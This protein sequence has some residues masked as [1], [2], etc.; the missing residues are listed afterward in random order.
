MPKNMGMPVKEEIMPFYAIVEICPVFS[1][2]FS[3]GRF[4][5]VPKDFRG[6]KIDVR[7]GLVEVI[8]LDKN[9]F[10]FR[11]GREVRANVG[12]KVTNEKGRDVNRLVKITIGLYVDLVLDCGLYV[13][14]HRHEVTGR[15]VDDGFNGAVSVGLKHYGVSISGVQGRID[16]L[17]FI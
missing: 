13:S 11:V 14:G 12:A 6:L 3:C 2:V 17:I 7:R 5:K 4:L 1:S 16:N 9:D 15:V 8:S 10:S